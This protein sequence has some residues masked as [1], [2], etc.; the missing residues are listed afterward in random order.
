[1]SAPVAYAQ[2]IDNPGVSMHFTTGL[3]LSMADRGHIYLLT[4]CHGFRPIGNDLISRDHWLCPRCFALVFP[5]GLNPIASFAARPVIMDWISHF[6]DPLTAEL[7]APDIF[8]AMAQVYSAKT[9]QRPLPPA[10]L[11]EVP[12]YERF[13]RGR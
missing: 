3:R 6:T 11:A 4:P 8:A 7:I 2:E 1:M 12:S 5:R 13:R 9:H 10:P